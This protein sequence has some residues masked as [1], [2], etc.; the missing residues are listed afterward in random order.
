MNGMEVLWIVGDEAL[1]AR[2]RLGRGEAVVLACPEVF[3]NSELARADH[4]DLLEALAGSGRLAPGR[5]PV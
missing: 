2:Q 1:V 5:L 3:R 4:L